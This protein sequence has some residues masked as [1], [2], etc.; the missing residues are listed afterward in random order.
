MSYPE[1]GRT[2]K[3]RNQESQPVE[4]RAAPNAGTHAETRIPG[5]EVVD[6]CSCAASR[7]ILGGGILVPTSL[8]SHFAQNGQS[9][10]PAAIHQDPSP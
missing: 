6:S 7:L 10:R 1:P 2:R 9:S 4:C 5:G 3:A 8:S